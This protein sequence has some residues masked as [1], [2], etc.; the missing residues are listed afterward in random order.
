MMSRKSQEKKRFSDWKTTLKK[1]YR[2]L[3]NGTFY[4]KKFLTDCEDIS[5]WRPL[6]LLVVLF[7]KQCL[8]K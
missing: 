8:L 3:A 2:Q 5:G 4:S 1:N 7:F 6:E